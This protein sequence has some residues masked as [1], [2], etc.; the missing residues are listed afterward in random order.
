MKRLLF[1]NFAMWPNIYK[2]GEPHSHNL[3]PKMLF[4]SLLRT[5]C[6]VRVKAE[7]L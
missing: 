1:V 5:Q 7:Q 3:D 4:A 6:P 2:L